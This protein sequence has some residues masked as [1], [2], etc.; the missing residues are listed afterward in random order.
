MSVTVGV[1]FSL[2]IILL[3]GPLTSSSGAPPRPRSWPTYCTGI[4][5]SNSGLKNRL[6][7]IAK[8]IG[9][10]AAKCQAAS[11]PCRD[12][13]ASGR[14]CMACSGSQ[15]HRPSWRVSA[16][17]HRDGRDENNGDAM[18]SGDQPVLQIQAAQPRHLHIG[19]E[20]RCVVDLLGIEK[21]LGG[22]KRGSVI[23]QR[24]HERFQSPHA[25]LHRHRQSQSSIRLRVCLRVA[26]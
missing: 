17:F 16:R 15:S 18:T 25:R 10:S 1:L 23:A 7:R 8:M 22:A 13:R 5:R 24:S 9:A 11:K 6:P 12:S 26:N 2:G 19:D 14:H 3:R 21:F 4:G 20:A